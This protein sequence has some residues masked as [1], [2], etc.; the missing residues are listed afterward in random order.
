MKLFPCPYLKSDVELSE[1]RETHIAFQHPDLLPEFINE[2][3]ETLAQPDDVR[4]G[5][6]LVSERR[7]YR[8]FD[9][10]RDGKYVAVVVVSETAPMTRHWIVTSFIT[11]RLPAGENE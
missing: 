9:H 5:K 2:I 10:V 6:R 1:E 7:F 4:K 11:R 8:W 3:G